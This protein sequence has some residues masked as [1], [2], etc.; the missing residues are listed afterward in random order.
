MTQQTKTEI[1]FKNKRLSQDDKR[2]I[3]YKC[4]HFAIKED[5][6]KMLEMRNQLWDDIY[7]FLVPANVLKKIKEIPKKFIK[8]KKRCNLD[9]VINVQNVD[10]NRPQYRIKSTKDNHLDYSLREEIPYFASTA[11]RSSDYF[12]WGDVKPLHKK[13]AKFFK[14][15]DKIETKK[16]E[17]ETEAYRILASCNTTK[18]LVELW[19]E[20]VNFLPDY[21]IENRSTN[22][23]NLPAV[24]N[25]TKL[26]NLLGVQNG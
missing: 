1:K 21:I 10:F 12:S 11:N 2:T 22:S 3:F 16:N 20:A 7:N 23:E 5:E 24:I 6:T 25:T 15:E 13:L 14:L 19:S 17:V 4:I 18:Q 8:Y 26:N 9:F